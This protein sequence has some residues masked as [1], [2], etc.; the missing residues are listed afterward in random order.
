M[1][2]SYGINQKSTKFKHDE[3]FQVSTLWIFE[4]PFSLIS[5]VFLIRSVRNLPMIFYEFFWQA[6]NFLANVTLTRRKINSKCA[7]MFFA[8]K[9]WRGANRTWW[10]EFD[11]GSLAC[12]NG[13]CKSVFI[14]RPSIA[15]N[16][17]ELM[18]HTVDMRT[19][20]LWSM[21]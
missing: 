15:E 18:V 3:K 2:Q 1:F 20:S 9:S 16:V 14:E 4:F 7:Q 19:K 8:P 17:R 12:K 10:R 13:K 21:E 6:T 5:K 11:I